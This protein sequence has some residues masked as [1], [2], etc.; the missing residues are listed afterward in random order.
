MKKKLFLLQVLAVLGG[1]LFI[2]PA[3]SQETDT[4]AVTD[5][6]SG[7]DNRSERPPF[8]GNY[9]I[10]S[11]TVAMPMAKTAE[12]LI[13]HRFGKLNSGQFDMFGLYAPSNIRIGLA[14]TFTDWLQVGIGSTKFNKLQD[15]NWKVGLLKQTRSSSIPVS[16][17]YFGD[18]GIDV[19]S[20]IF[21]KFT[22]RL[23][24]FHQLMVARRFNSA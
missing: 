19:R 9:L 6:P 14:Y 3:F 2:T 18:V 5:E 23:S 12:F 16:V 20:D 11:Q 10:N 21:P 8:E 17:T 15:L 24:Y 22:N 7:K 4:T 13:Q 1:A